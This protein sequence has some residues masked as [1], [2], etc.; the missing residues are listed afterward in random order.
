[1]NNLHILY[2]IQNVGGIDFAQDIGD[3]VPVKHTLRGLR[4]SGHQVDCLKLEGNRVQIYQDMNRLTEAQ[5]APLGI[6]SSRIFRLIEGGIRRLQKSFH[7]PYF[8][9]FDSY[10]FSEACAR[11]LPGYHLVH[12]HN[13]LFCL[14]TA[15]ACA[16]SGKP[17]VLTF[18]ADP[19]LERKVVGVPLRGVHLLVASQE[20][21]F[22][23]RLAR[24]IICVSEPA[25]EHLVTNWKL[26]PEKIQVMPNGVD[27]ER[28]GVRYDSQKAR[29]ELGLGPEQIIGFV[30]SFQLWHGLDLLVESFC[31][32][33][34]N[35]PQTRLLLVGDGP[36]RSVVEKAAVDLGVSQSVTITGLVPQT[37]VPKLLAA[38]DIAVIPYP[39]FSREIWFSP[40]KLYEYMAA[41]K[42]IVASRSGQITEV[43]QD[44]LTGLLVKPGDA[45]EMAQAIR[46]L[47]SDPAERRSLG[48]NARR[49]ALERHSWESY[50]Q[51]LEE[52][53][54]SVLS[55]DRASATEKRV[56]I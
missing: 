51:R 56:L 29:A 19:I 38:V 24:R 50:I 40:L 11:L 12:E 6:S 4:K 23:Y 18:S 55:E 47:L 33:Q 46:R 15:W 13:G 37:R 32:L 26:D 41:G 2:T 31:R 17:Y 53:Y 1:M 28:F 9:F 39:R 3:T 16:R 8:A 25:K 45:D 10:R 35:F 7:L 34:K 22:T 42:A 21:R 14:G 43:I 27:V 54:Q 36:A 52:I 5:T 20:A 49:Q 30:G 48:E 44:G